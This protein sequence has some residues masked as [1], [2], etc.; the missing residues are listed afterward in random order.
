MTLTI[1]VTV[2]STR[3]GAAS[4][5]AAR[6]STSCASALAA[7]LAALPTAVLGVKSMPSPRELNAPMISPVSTA[8]A[9]ASQFAS[10]R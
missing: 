2:T 9:L 5:F 3:L 10:K 8:M 4:A 7:D 6:C 1:P